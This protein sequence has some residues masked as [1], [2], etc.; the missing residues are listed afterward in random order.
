MRRV[1]AIE[2]QKRNPGR[3]NI[4]LDEEFAFGLARIV[5]AWLQVGQL[6]TE[7][8]ISQLL[9][10]DSREMAMQKALH[11]LS[12]RPRSSQEVR[13]NLDKHE[14]TPAVI[15]ETLSRLESAGL[16]N[17]QDFARAWIE[18]RNAFRPRGHRALKMELRQKGLP[19]TLISSTLAETTDEESLARLAA[20]KQLRKVQ[21]LDWQGFRNKMGA[22]LAR[23]GFS[24]RVISD[25]VRESWRSIHPEGRQPILENEDE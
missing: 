2:V 4:Y 23:R 10:Q 13:K 6:L 19:E 25:V 15:E 14:I 1:T 20:Q 9:D 18:N 7:E 21:D 24:Y 11:F 3:V 16:L 8:K 22:F 17:D 5:A 12:Y